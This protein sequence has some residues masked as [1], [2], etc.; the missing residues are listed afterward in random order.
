MILIKVIV[1]SIR[2]TECEECERTR[3]MHVAHDADLAIHEELMSESNEAS[4]NHISEVAN[5]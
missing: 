4:V 3:L 1:M 5:E 2:R